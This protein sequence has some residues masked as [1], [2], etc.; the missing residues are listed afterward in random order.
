MTAKRKV[1]STGFYHV[2]VQARAGEDLFRDDTD[3]KTYLG[4]LKVSKVFNCQRVHVWAL[5]DNHAHLLIEDR[6]GSLSR[7]MYDANSN[8]AKAFNKRHKRKGSLFAGRFWSEP[9]E[10]YSRLLA[11]MDYIHNN[12]QVAGVC[13]AEETPCRWGSG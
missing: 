11:V 3:R 5:M 7:A 8:Y 2:I 13:R 12:P 9:I 1:S 6:V 4:L 10:N